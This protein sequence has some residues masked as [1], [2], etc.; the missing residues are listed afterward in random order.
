MKAKNSWSSL[1]TRYVL[2]VKLGN[3]PETI[4]PFWFAK[5][6]S[7]Y[8]HLKDAKI[9]QKLNQTQNDQNYLMWIE[10]VTVQT[11]R[12]V[13]TMKTNR[14]WKLIDFAEVPDCFK[15]LN[16]IYIE[17]EIQ[18]GAEISGI[19]AYQKEKARLIKNL[20]QSYRTNQFNRIQEEHSEFKTKIK[21]IKPNGE[22]N[23]LDIE[24]EEFDKIKELLCK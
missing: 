22:T 3:K 15:L 17:S 11:T 2:M 20:I 10:K 16:R 14:T 18:N 9:A 1:K 5:G 4:R 6:W 7:S 12:E 24:N 21:I 23:W 8:E 13:I 19:Q